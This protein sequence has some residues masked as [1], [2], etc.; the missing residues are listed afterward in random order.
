MTENGALYDPIDN[1]K[2]TEWMDYSISEGR[3]PRMFQAELDQL[4]IK[5]GHNCRM[6]HVRNTLVGAIDAETEV[7]LS[8]SS[9]NS[10]ALVFNRK[11]TDV[12]IMVFLHQWER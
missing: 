2:W 7:K 8:L 10:P 4:E 11:G 1:P 6:I 3:Y 9:E 12:F 5:A